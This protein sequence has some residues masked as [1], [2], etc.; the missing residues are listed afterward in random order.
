[1]IQHLQVKIIHMPMFQQSLAQGENSWATV[2]IETK[3][4]VTYIL[5]HS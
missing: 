2:R 1:M 4:D 3:R 5:F